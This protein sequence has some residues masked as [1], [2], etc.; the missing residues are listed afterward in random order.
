MTMTS[1]IGW[2]TAHLALRSPAAAILC[3][4]GIA[5]GSM[6]TGN[7]GPLVAITFDDAYKSDYS[8]ALPELNERNMTATAYVPSGFVGRENRMT[9]DDVRSL[10]STKW[11]IGA[12]TITH[13]DLTTLPAPEMEHEIRASAG[14]VE[15]VINLPVRTFATPFGA[16]GD[17]ELAVIRDT[18]KTHVR[19]WTDDPTVDGLNKLPLADPHQINRW[20]ITANTTVEDVCKAV[21]AIPD[22]YVLVA[23]FHEIVSE[24]AIDWQVNQSVFEGMLDCLNRREGVLISELAPKQ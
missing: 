14:E 9:W 23:S 19:G 4:T 1:S 8:I 13:P 24:A 16:Y 6:S 3:V 21:D 18:Y 17:R 10:A 11:E 20:A 5:W 15:D 2:T 7:D 12:H 22:G